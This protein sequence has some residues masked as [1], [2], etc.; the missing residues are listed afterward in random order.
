MIIIEGKIFNIQKYSIHDGPGIRNTVFMMGCPLRCWWCHNPESQSIKERL[1]IFPN[2]CIGC[3][4]CIDACTQGAIREVNGIVV[5]DKSKCTNCGDCTLVCYSEARQMTG[6]TMTVEEVANEVLKDRHFFEESGGGVTFSGGEPLFQVDFLTEL[7]K[8]MKDNNIHTTVDTSGFTTRKNLE[9]ISKYVDL[10]LYD[11]KHMDGI[12]HEKYTG[13]DNKLILENLKYLHDLNKDI[14]IRI[15][16]IPGI[17]NQ[18]KSLKAF[19][20]FIKTLPNIG[21]IDLLPYHK[22]GEEKYNRLGIKY[23]MLDVEEPNEDEMDFALKIMES[24]RK[25]VQIGG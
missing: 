8:E 12:K 24:T 20:D 6:K 10:F 9:Q 21:R 2:R 22:I 4:A 14:I 5:T 7:L 16:I 23:K 13:V 1:M 17:N 3:M 18:E 25:K 11:L 19:R 15:P